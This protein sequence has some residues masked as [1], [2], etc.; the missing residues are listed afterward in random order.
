[1]ETLIINQQNKVV[2]TRVM[3]RTILNVA[4]AVAKM[5][6]ISKNTELSVLIVDNSYMQE[7]NFIYRQQNRPTDVLSF[8]MNELADEE[9]DMGIEEEVNA[10]GDIVISLEQAQLQS[11]EFGHSLE[12]ELGYL[13]AHGILHLLG[14][15]HEDD[16]EKELMRNLEEK[17]MQKV[18]LER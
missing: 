11:E 16:T 18:K 9:P 7:L 15:D 14:Y 6:K 10:L 3:Q 17:I 13:V 1:M 4:N 5:A 12:R 2:Y 8:A